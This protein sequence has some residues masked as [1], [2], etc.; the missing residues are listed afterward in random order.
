MLFLLSPA[1]KLDYDSPLHIETHTQPLFVDQAAGLIKVL[2]TKSAEDIS[3]LMSLSPALSE[4]NV[5]RYASW[6][7]SFTQANSRQAVLAFNGDVYEGLEAAT[8][9]AK[10]LDWA[11]EHV[12]ILSGLYGVLRPLDLMQPYR[13]EMG[14]RLATPKGK[15]LY[16]YWGP[17]IA[18]YLNERQAG[19]KAPVI[20]N[21]ASEEYF[22]SVDLK[23]LKARVVQCVFQDWKNGAWK[24]ISFHAKRARG[25]MARYA[26]LHKVSK[27]EGLQ[28]FDLEGYKFDAS[29]SS[30]DKLVFRRKV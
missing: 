30:E 20:V 3:E 18:E 24:V 4:L 10:Q 17:A 11:Q 26:I 22:K 21:L 15:N 1:K 19:Q 9:S 6:K 28:G 23:T 25:L 5:Q 16:E 2:K 12:A 14:T 29:A 13:L 27:P 8:L 7:R